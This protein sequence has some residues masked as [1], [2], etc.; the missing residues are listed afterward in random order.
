MVEGGMKVGGYRGSRIDG[1]RFSTILDG[2]RPISDCTWLKRGIVGVC[3]VCMLGAAGAHK[4]AWERQAASDLR[5]ELPQ[6]VVIRL[7][8]YGQGGGCGEG[9]RGSCDVRCSY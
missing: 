8:P 7:A 1:T 6:L 5:H 4:D 2:K 9:P 3:H